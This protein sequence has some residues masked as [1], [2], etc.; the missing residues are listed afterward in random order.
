MKCSRIG[1]AALLLAV[2]GVLPVVAMPPLDP[3][4]RYT[5]Q[6]KGEMRFAHLKSDRAVRDP[7][8][9]GI[10]NRPGDVQPLVTGTWLFPVVLI[11]YPDRP[12]IY[13]TPEFQSELFGPWPTTGSATDYYAEVSYGRL[14]LT[15]TVTGWYRAANNAIYYA[16][17]GGPGD[18]QDLVREAAAASDATVNYAQYDHDGDGYVDVFSCVH[19]GYGREEGGL[20]DIW[21]HRSSLSP[22]YTTNDDRP[23][24][25]GQKIIIDVYTMMPERSNYSQHGTMVS[26]GVF[27]HEWGHGFDLPD[28]YD[29]DY[30]GGCGLG[31]WSLMASGSWGANG[32]TPWWPAHA[33]AWSKMEVGW[34]NP[35]AVRRDDL[36]SLKQVETNSDAV[37]TIG[38][39]RTFKEYF[40]IENR[41]K[42]G[43]DALLPGQGLLIYHV[44]DSIVASRRSSNSINAAGAWPHG[45]ALEQADNL[46]ELYWH[47]TDRGDAG[48]PWPGSTLNTVFDSTTNPNTQTNYPA[49]SP[50]L[51]GSWARQ[52]PASAATMTCS[53]SSGV[54]GVF[55]GGPDASG[56]WWLDSDSAGPTYTWTDITSTG[57]L[58][59]SGDDARF[60]VALPYQFSLYG[61]LYSTMWVSTNGWVSF[62]TD[63]GA[64]VPFNAAVPA[65]TA[66][67]AAVYVLWDDLNLVP[68]DSGY[69]Y[70]R[71]YGATPN[72]STIVM[73]KNA[74]RKNLNGGYLRP[75]NP[76]S[77]ELVLC[78]NGRIYCHYRDCAVG[79][80]VYNWGRSATVGVE[81]A[82]GTTG[83]Q[84]L[85]DGAPVGNLLAGERAIEFRPPLNDVGLVAIN[86]PTGTVDSTQVVT[87][88]VTLFNF[89]NVN[90]TYYVKMN[91]G[92]GYADSALVLNHAPWS[93]VVQPLPNWT[94]GPRGM[95]AVACSTRLAGDLNSLNDTAALKVEV[96]VVDAKAVS[97]DEPSGV[98]DS[99]TSA[100][101]KA[102]VSNPGTTDIT[103]P[104]ILTIGTLYADT[105]T[106]AMAAGTQRS[107][108]FDIW[109]VRERGSLQM[110]CST[111]LTGE[112]YPHDDTV[113]APIDVRVLDAV[114]VSVDEPVGTC[115]S[116]TTVIPKATV[117]NSSTLGQ[118][119]DVILDVGTVYTDTQPV[120]LGSGAQTQVTFDPWVATQRGSHVVR[121]TTALFGDMDHST[122]TASALAGVRL[123]DAK[124][125]A[126]VEP[127]GNIDS[128][129]TVTPRATVRNNGTEPGTITAIMAVDAFYADTQSV[130]LG[131]GAQ[132]L[133][134]FDPWLAEQMGSHTASCTLEMTGDMDADNDTGSAPVLVRVDAI[135]AEVV[136]IDAP[137]GPFDSG[138][139]VV[140]LVT[141][142]NS[143]TDPVTIPA[144]VTIGAFYCDTQTVALNSG[145]QT[146]LAYDPWPVRQRGTHVVKCTTALLLDED[147]VN[148]TAS[149]SVT[150]S[151]VNALP[152]AIVQPAGNWDSGSTITPSVTVRNGGT[153]GAT[154]PV[155]LR[156]GTFYDDTQ[157]V[158]LGPGA[159]SPLSFDVWVADQRGS[160]TVRCS[161]ALPGD[162]NSGDDVRIGGVTIR[163]DDAAVV[164]IVRPTNTCDS[165]TAVTPQA[166][167]RNLSTGVQTFPV[168]FRI[169]AT[170]ADTQSVMLGPNIQAAVDFDPWLPTVRGPHVMR[171]TTGLVG[172]AETAND[173]MN[174]ITVVRVTDAAVT[175]ISGPTDTV[176]AYSLITPYAHVANR[177]SYATTVPVTLRIGP[178]YTSTQSVELAAGDE[179]D[180][181][182]TPWRARPLGPSA[183]RCSTS[184]AGDLVRANNVVGC[185]VFVR[186]TDVSVVVLGEPT[187]SYDSGARVTPQAVIANAGTSAAIV[188][189]ILTIGSFYTDTQNVA[190]AAGSWTSVSFDPWDAL[191]TGAHTARC[192]VALDGDRNPL[193][194][195]RVSQCTVTARPPAGVGW[196]PARSMPSGPSGKPVKAGGWLAA[197]P[198]LGRVYAAKGNK[199]GDFYSFEPQS[200]RWTP[201]ETIPRGAEGKLPAAGA[202]GTSDNM[203]YIYALKGNNTDGFWRYNMLQDTWERLQP[204]HAGLSRRRAKAGTDVAFTIE[205]DGFFVYAL[206]GGTNEFWRY[207][208]ARQDWESLPSPPP[209]LR[210]KWDKGS[211]LVTDGAQYIYAHKGKY[212]DFYRFD[213]AADTWLTRRYSGMPTYSFLTG[214]TTRPGDG[215]NATW[216]DGRIYA[217]KGSNTTEFWCYTPERDSWGELD[218]LPT[219][220]T[221]RARVKVKDGA[222]VAAFSDSLIVGLK[223][224][225]STDAWQ[226][227]TFNPMMA[228]ARWLRSGV[229]ANGSPAAADRFSIAPNPLR[230]GFLYLTTGP[231][232]RSVTISVCDA[233]GRRV[234]SQTTK[235]STSRTLSLDV[236][237]L[238]AGVYLVRLDAGAFSDCRKLVIE[239]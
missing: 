155:V 93:S 118:A 176:E 82:T 148:D 135:D 207:S 159:Q 89:S 156:I 52:I 119:F 24:F 102:T 99:G 83:L 71:H 72:C 161:T 136:S 65:A 2:L 50:L 43:F 127:V 201:R 32:S 45:V 151:V 212:G 109:N 75:I 164:A 129:T 197:A 76:M 173:T 222:D 14:N 54:R 138:A 70:Y 73:W 174:G 128:G 234:I 44:D 27:C 217:L 142:R 115:D 144:I 23:G 74:R 28:L 211:W 79:D 38:R 192:S 203:T 25:P 206:K 88:S 47:N 124:L 35:R 103:V 223:G 64:S 204:L 56:Y 15:G 61:Q 104:V 162:L 150:V 139:T 36:F 122:D 224:N 97:L 225:R 182:F 84:Y 116:G 218:T 125:V 202:S 158:T 193:N 66:P 130:A 187:G 198:S 133:L 107:V 29:T 132:T 18:A 190:L 78:E 147:P 228:S 126:I 179:T 220:G 210:P 152:V 178:G 67:N 169:G 87:P 140:P 11:D 235:S 68:S 111:A 172:D 232:D 92:A 94:A 238:S 40:L 196:T 58:L 200:G 227:L 199:T 117:R 30:G 3:N 33:D 213:L 9:R 13:T 6:D 80:T 216:T 195:L 39:N 184:L 189:A 1:P 46:N 20:G 19:A 153:A 168:I 131:P 106:V 121:C 226:Y 160:H 120:L 185:S 101:P 21:S 10:I 209:G 48:D 69:L 180:V 4:Y 100:V 230:S 8:M 55:R 149:S 16:D 215:S 112:L 63:P 239:R 37:W 17:L 181:A 98:V 91:I 221:S 41:R 219:A 236:R 186:T 237:S 145:A 183:V 163:S 166:V 165:G 105:Q 86:A 134:P 95:Q 171:C 49:A 60:S 110:R 5:D 42:T 157:S 34:L 143:G 31:Y 231:S 77:F 59:G 26:I 208:L 7:G 114:A 188:P 205:P 154:I 137:A 12:A 85:L 57:T 177:S 194:D 53:L 123:I 167:I 141:V 229:T 214:R 51:T 90:Q 96:R 113:S 233:L 146:Q 191:Q 22:A 175:S 108:L 170:Y 62:G 81:D